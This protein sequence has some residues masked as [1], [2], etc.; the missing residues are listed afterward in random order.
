MKALNT[1]FI[2]TAVCAAWVLGFPNP[3]AAF[4]ETKPKH[5]AS[6]LLDEAKLIDY[7]QRVAAKKIEMDRLNEDLKKGTDEIDA[8]E[9]RIQKVGTAAD[10]ATKQLELLTTQK[11][12]AAL[13][14]DLLN[15]RIEAERLKGDGLRLLQI[16]N[17]K[18]QDAVAIR[19]E[20]TNARTALV[21]A[22]TRQLATKAP[23]TPEDSGPEIPTAKHTSK[24][25]PTLI[26]W[27]KKL[28][29]AERAT[30]LA[31]THARDAML[32]ATAK[33]RETENATARA[34]KKQEEVAL[35]KNP[36]FQGGNDPLSPPAKK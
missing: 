13:E 4:S 19:N 35:D 29:K 6:T 5:N 32:A 17:K 22:E 10:D 31:D 25:E 21:A 30:A 11:K 1:S 8:I 24:N 18:A 9:K 27:R 20:E 34:E 3:R 23:N 36:S 15:L 2:A 28:E 14:L 7:E 33:L 16:A 12:R 26:E